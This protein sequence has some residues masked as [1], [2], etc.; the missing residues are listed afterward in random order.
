MDLEKKQ[1][2]CC[3]HYSAGF[4]PPDAMQLVVI[5]D[6]VL[7]GEHEVEGVRYPSPDHMSGWW[8]TTSLYSGNLES[9]KTVHFKHIAEAL[10]NIAQYMGLPHGYRFVLGGQSEHVWFDSEVAKGV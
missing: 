1:E 2:A 8:L 9:L 5:S 10:P 6:G 7:L 3:A 4:L